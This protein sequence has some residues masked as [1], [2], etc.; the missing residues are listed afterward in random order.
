ME[1]KTLSTRHYKA[2]YEIR[3]QEV[4]LK[5]CDI[6]VCKYAYT[7][8][9]WWIGNSRDAYRLCKKQGLSHLRAE[10]KAI[11][12]TAK[13]HGTYGKETLPMVAWGKGVGRLGQ[14]FYTYMKFPHNYL[15][16]LY[17]AG[18][19]KKNIKRE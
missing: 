4:R 14:A 16:M 19:R 5:G 8:E 15:Q 9:G 11:N 12:A 2:G 13:A 3:T 1:T 7:P 18:I 6:H 10:E 17:D